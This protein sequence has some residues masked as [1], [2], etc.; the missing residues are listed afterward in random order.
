MIVSDPLELL[1]SLTTVMQRQGTCKQ[2][3]TLPYHINAL[4]L[5]KYMNGSC[6]G[7]SLRFNWENF[8]IHNINELE[9]NS[10]MSACVAAYKS[11]YVN[12]RRQNVSRTYCWKY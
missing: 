1:A 8:T 7:V 6:A 4:P 12:L 11:M 5:W 2:K 9:A 10:Y 3:G